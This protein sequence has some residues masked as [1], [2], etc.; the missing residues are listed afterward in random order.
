[1]VLALFLSSWGRIVL[2]IG[3]G[4]FILHIATKGV[5]DDSRR[6]EKTN[7]FEFE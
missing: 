5:E 3:S 6:I 1:M 4:S 7:Q 2:E